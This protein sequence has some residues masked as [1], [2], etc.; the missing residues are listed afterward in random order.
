MKSSTALTGG[1]VMLFCAAVIFLVITAKNHH[2]E[3]PDAGNVTGPAQNLPNTESFEC[4]ESTNDHNSINESRNDQY[5]EKPQIMEMPQSY[6]AS[7][8]ELLIGKDGKKLTLPLIH[9]SVNGDIEGFTA[10]V[11]VHQ[12]YVNSFDSTI[13]ALYTFPLPENAAVDSMILEIGDKR[14]KGVIKERQ[15]A[16]AI[17]EEARKRG[18][19]T[20]LL[21]QQHP[22]IFT[23]SVANI[24]PGDTIVITISYLQQ[25]KYKNGTCL[26]N[27]PMVVGPRYIPGKKLRDESVGT[28]NPTDQVPDA[29]RI[30]PPILPPSTRSGHDISLQVTIH[31][32]LSIIELTS[33]SHRIAVSDKDSVKIVRISPNDQIPNKDFMLEYTVAEED[34]NTVFLTHKK[35]EQDGFFQLIMIPKIDIKEKE[36]VPRELVFVVD[37]SGSMGGFPLEKCKEL[38]KLSLAR[39]RRNDLFRVIKFSGST[40]ILSPTALMATDANI[41][42]A[43]DFVDEMAGGGGTEMMK[44]INAIFDATPADGRKR[45]VLFMTD[46]YVGNDREIIS[47]IQSRLGDS[48]VFS[49]G[50]GSSVNRYLLEGMGYAGRGN[51]QIIRQD[52]E[53]KKTIDEFYADIDAPVLTN[54]SLSWD[55][56]Q[57]IDPQPAQLPDLF[58]NQPLTVTG[59][60]SKGGKGTL[61]I[62]GN[63]SGGR[64]YRKRIDVDLPNTMTANSVLPP[65]WARKK[66]EVIDLLGS[67]LFDSDEVSAD[68]V[69]NTILKLG[70]EY[71]LMTQYTSFVAV[72]DA[73][74][75]RSGKWTTVEQPVELPEGVTE[76]SQPGYRFTAGGGD[77]RARMTSCGVL[78]SM[79]GSCCK[80]AASADVYGKGGFATDIDEII[81]GIGGLKTGGSGGV[82]RKGVAGIGYGSGYGSGFGGSGTGGID[83]LIGIK[84]RGTLA[85]SAPEFLKG[86][87]LNGG[88]SKASIMRVVMQNLAALR[89][90]F[91]KRLRDKPGLNG[92]LSIKFKIDHK[93][94]VI[95]CE[96]VSSSVND[97]LLEDQIVAKIKRWQFESID[98]AGDTTEVVYPFVFSL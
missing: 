74:R 63:L 23:Q 33:P 88:R 8:G 67:R 92:K 98:I 96:V 77:P 22:N 57:I 44:A 11:T 17:Y 56:I 27:F 45:L 64:T 84:K 66:I 2:D 61:T 15:E 1:V 16:R 59:K 46:G 86:A 91:N 5:K 18:K 48:R 13:E 81:S 58:Q 24:L 29:H 12:I 87:A 19:T 70:L 9:T 42:K 93:G 73:V 36:I 68:S 30:T 26:F 53:T 43:L 65:L 76:K 41:K 10:R 54:L 78:G 60:Y 80:S 6:S 94:T 79:R 35:K 95:L 7:Q 31:K 55:G 71:K 49:L 52:G 82:G 47:T 75:N 40:E 97:T 69:K 83:S 32:C 38:M 72:D 28:E 4:T 50:V 62:T 14:I 37:N 25:L 20:S 3:K 90:V 51:C 39:M 34:I 89:Y 85:I 21:E